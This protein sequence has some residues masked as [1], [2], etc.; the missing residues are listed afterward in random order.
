MSE[1]NITDG[2]WHGPKWEG[3]IRKRRIGTHRQIGQ[4]AFCIHVRPASVAL[5]THRFALR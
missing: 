5:I 1:W 4:G 3:R 2:L